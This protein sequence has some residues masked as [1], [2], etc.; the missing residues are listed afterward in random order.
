MKNLSA[1][2][3]SL[4]FRLP[5]MKEQI[6]CDKSLDRQHLS[7]A[8]GIRGLACLIVLIGHSF[9]VTTPS[10]WMLIRGVPKI[11]V[12][13]FFVLSAFL[14]TRQLLSRPFSFSTLVDYALSR[15]LRI[16]PAYV[17]A[18]FLYYTL[19][20]LGIN[21]HQDLASALLLQKGFGHLW[22][23][24]VEMKFYVV[25]PIICLL[26][27]ILS[28][29]F[30]FFLFCA[31]A[32]SLIFT[33]AALYPWWETPENT[34]QLGY[35]A[36]VFIMGSLA[37]WLH[38]SKE[39][40]L[41]SR[42]YC[43]LLSIAILLVVVF[44]VVLSKAGVFGDPDNFLM[45]KQ[46]MFG[47]LFS[48]LSFFVIG[49]KTAVSRLFDMQWLSAIGRWSYSIYLFHW[50]FVVKIKLFLLGP[51]AAMIAIGISLIIGWLG[52]NLIES[53]LFHLRHKIFSLL[54]VQQERQ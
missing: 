26:F 11:G 15:I 27:A 41:V 20:G 5:M 38:G 1:P 8:D 23:I 4:F 12:W 29:F 19:G 21:S 30:S 13:L 17:V 10:T 48:C 18:V 52:Y 32:C 35:Y 43:N 2:F 31:V 45:D 49:R 28:R 44:I 46:I 33:V 47:F 53:P 39:Y 51:P 6:N 3:P 22:T 40:K 42:V 9:A 16:F 50:F 36:G 34:L 7:A 25:L 37:A 24:P 54:V 14:L